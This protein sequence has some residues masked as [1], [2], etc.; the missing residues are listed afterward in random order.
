MRNDGYSGEKLEKIG[1]K[2]EKIAGVIQKNSQNA[3][4]IYAIGGV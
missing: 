4:N 2:S 1:K 3:P